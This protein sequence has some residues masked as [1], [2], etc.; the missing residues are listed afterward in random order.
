M[1]TSSW[2]LFKVYQ[3]WPD[4]P[5]HIEENTSRLILAM[6][7]LCKDHWRQI[8]SCSLSRL[9]RQGKR[10]RVTEIPRSFIHHGCNHTAISETKRC[11]ERSRVLA[12]VEESWYDM[13]AVLWGLLGRVRWRYESMR[14]ALTLLGSRGVALFQCLD[15]IFCAS[16]KSGRRLPLSKHLHK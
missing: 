3:I 11:R 13:I 9:E 16:K 15:R 14:P 2:C 1:L 7:L 4:Q 12:R 10:C 6:S 8:Q 5:L